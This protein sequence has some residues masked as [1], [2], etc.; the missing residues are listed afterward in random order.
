M[1]YY[2]GWI[3]S[4]FKFGFDLNQKWMSADGLTL[5]MVF[6][7]TGVY[8]SFNL[9]RGTFTLAGTPDVTGPSAPSSLRAI[10]VP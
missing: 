4:T 7:G 9:I 6:S 5:Y 8:D 10:S 3:D 2:E 1:A